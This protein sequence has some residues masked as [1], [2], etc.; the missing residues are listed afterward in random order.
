MRDREASAPRRAV[1]GGCLSPPTMGGWPGLRPD[2]EAL[3]RRFQEAE[4]VRYEDFVSVWREKR[5]HTIFYGKIRT[6]EQIKFTREAL[7]L[8]WPYFLPPYTF[9]IRVGALYLLYGLY[10]TQL[11]QPKEKIRVALK[12]WSEV[13]KFQQELLEAEHYDAAYIFRKLRMDRAFFFT[14]MPKFLSFR[15]KKKMH[16]RTEM[17]TEFRDPT[18]R[19]AMLNPDDFLEVTVAVA[20]NLEFTEAKNVHDHYQKMKCLISVDQSHPDK[21]IDLIKDDFIAN[22]KDIISEYQRW[23][24]NKMTPLGSISSCRD[25]SV[26]LAHRPWFTVKCVLFQ[27]PALATLDEEATNERKA[28]SQESEGSKRARALTEI[29]SRSYSAVAPVS[30]SRR[31]RQVR[32]APSETGSDHRKTASPRAKRATNMLQPT[33]RTETLQ[34]KGTLQAIKDPGVK[35]TLSMP[36]ISEGDAED[37]DD[38]DNDR[39][40]D[41]GTVLHMRQISYFLSGKGLVESSFK[42]TMP[43]MQWRCVKEMC[44]QPTEEVAQVPQ[45][46]TGKLH[47]P[48]LMSCEGK[49]LLHKVTIEKNMC[50]AA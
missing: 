36:V 8:V 25:L 9:Q 17:K 39:S 2:C 38:Y 43:C 21:A 40:S 27:E 47:M 32:L 48:V 7:A 34:N 41:E 46:Q 23:Q 45:S 24:K 49:G 5:F 37:D 14:A 35:T 50:E 6:L 20:A 10:N 16:E 30:R 28:F 3:L 18:D 4:S 15:T 29:K 22:F 33:K 26:P 13:A 42:W 44:L 1:G 31:H 12:D 11:C 19:V